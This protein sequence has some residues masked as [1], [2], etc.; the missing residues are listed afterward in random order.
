MQ[1]EVEAVVA[2]AE[3]IQPEA[4]GCDGADLRAEEQH[5][6]AKGGNLSRSPVLSGGAN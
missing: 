4:L 6:P 1:D 5:P 3:G 2:D